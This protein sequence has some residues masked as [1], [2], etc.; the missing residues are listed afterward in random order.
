MEYS[1]NLMALST[2]SNIC[3]N[4]VLA[5]VGLFCYRTELGLNAQQLPAKRQLQDD[6]MRSNFMASQQA[7]A[8]RGLFPEQYVSDR[9]I[10]PSLLG[11]IMRKHQ[12]A[13]ITP[14]VGG[15][16]Q[17]GHSQEARRCIRCVFRR[18]GISAPGETSVL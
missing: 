3:I 11:E 13:F 16:I 8:Q 18:L 10:Y 12:V 4:S 6:F 2:N 14:C 15:D 7:R 5:L 1:H 17:S 9:S